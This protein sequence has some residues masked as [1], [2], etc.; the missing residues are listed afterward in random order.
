[1]SDE[2]FR[3]M[4]VEEKPDGAVSRRIGDRRFSEL[5]DDDVLIEVRYSSLNYKDSLS[6]TGHKGVTKRYPHTPGI[7]AAGVVQRSKS[8]AFASGDEVIVTGY[9]LGMNTSGGLAGLICVPEQ[10]VVQKPDNLSLRESMALGTA[11]FTAALAINRLQVAEILPDHGEVLITGSTGG[12]GTLSVALLTQLGYRVVALTGKTQLTDYLLDLGAG[13]VMG[14]EAFFSQDDRPLLRT[15]WSGVVDTV[16]GNILATALKTTAYGG[17]VVCCGMAASPQLETNVYP[18]ILRDVSLLGVS[19]AE[20][21]MPLRKR[22][23]EQLGSDWKIAKLDTITREICLAEV[24]PYITD[25]LSGQNYGRM[26]VR[27]A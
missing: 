23:W 17:A 5:P 3:A 26:V 12:V 2:T 11:G 8:G 15:R 19:S 10:W 22:M 20:C 14:R 21:P 27:I 7:D 13:E 6:A 18:F 4:I 16:G 9:D 24:E 1:M 25:F